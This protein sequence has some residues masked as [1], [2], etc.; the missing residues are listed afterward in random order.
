MTRFNSLVEQ[1]WIQVN[2]G[3]TDTLIRM[4]GCKRMSVWQGPSQT[5]FAF[6]PERGERSWRNQD[7]MDFVLILLALALLVV[8]A[9][10]CSVSSPAEDHRR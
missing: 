3:W 1:D 9:I 10:L 2:P 6:I 4:Y 5:V 8:S 7:F